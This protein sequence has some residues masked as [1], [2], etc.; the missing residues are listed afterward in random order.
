M[1]DKPP[2]VI[3]PDMLELTAA[4][5]PMHPASVHCH[6][7]NTCVW[8]GGEIA[9]NEDRS[10]AGLPFGPVIALDGTVVDLGD[11]QDLLTGWADSHCQ[12]DDCPHTSAA[13]AA[14]RAQDPAVLVAE[15][16]ELKAALGRLAGK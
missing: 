16:T 12:R 5:A 8:S 9:D 13:V 4:R 7:C 11:A 3:P 15:I 6:T 10:I 1:I 2:P 14:A